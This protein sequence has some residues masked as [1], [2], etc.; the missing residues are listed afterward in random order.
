MIRRTLVPLIASGLLLAATAGSALAKCEGPNP[1]AFCSE[2]VASVSNGGGSYLRLTA[3]EATTVDVAVTQGE[4]PFA[5]ESV[6]LV[7][8][9]VAGGDAIEIPAQG[10][11]GGI[12]HAEVTLPE[13]GSWTVVAELGV[14][15]MT[16][17]MTY[18][19][20]RVAAAPQAPDGPVAT[21]ATPISPAPPVLPIALAIAAVAVAAGALTA[22]ALRGRARRRVSAG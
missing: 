17:R 21:P 10:G 22:A 13:G 1:P 8:H 19:P 20:F 7:F 15:G 18:E 11:A 4:Q 2:V 14:D 9:R 6:V 3:G 16:Q 5:A 12:W